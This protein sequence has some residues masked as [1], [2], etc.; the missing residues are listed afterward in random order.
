MLLDSSLSNGGGGGGGY[1]MSKL[2]KVL[3][4]ASKTIIFGFFA[5]FSEVIYCTPIFRLIGSILQF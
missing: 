5:Q 1:T 4:K 3:L 2:I